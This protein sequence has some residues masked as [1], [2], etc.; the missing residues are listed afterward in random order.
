MSKMNPQ[1]QQQIKA[2]KRQRRKE[3]IDIFVTFTGYI[4]TWGIILWLYTQ[5]Y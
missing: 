1:L 5:L 2:I 4:V 3:N